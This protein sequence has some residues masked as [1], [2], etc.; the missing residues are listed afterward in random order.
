MTVSTPSLLRVILH[1]NHYDGGI[2]DKGEHETVERVALS[3][4]IL[5]CRSGFVCVSACVCLCLCLCL[6]AWVDC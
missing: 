3:G 2:T 6:C 4:C 5:D 1:S